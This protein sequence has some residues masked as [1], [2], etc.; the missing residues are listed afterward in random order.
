MNLVDHSGV[1]IRLQLAMTPVPATR[2]TRKRLHRGQQH[3][4]VNPF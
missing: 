1:K 4:P 2:N 3:D